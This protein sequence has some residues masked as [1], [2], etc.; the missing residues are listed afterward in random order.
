LEEAM[1][2]QA[3]LESYLREQGVAFETQRHA[4]AFTAQEVAATEHVPGRMFAK[5]VMVEADGSLAMLAL[6]AP[7]RVSVEE[8]R[9]TLEA[10]ELRLAEEDEFAE[11]FEGCEV[12]AMSPLGNLHDLPVYVDQELAEQETIVFQ[13]GTHRDTISM[14]YADFERLVGPRVG[15]LSYP[16]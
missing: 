4:T 11:R 16:R 2:Y 15:V 14:R 9:R 13:A 5:V 3:E 1:S 7:A 12:G 6:P 8:A 10:E